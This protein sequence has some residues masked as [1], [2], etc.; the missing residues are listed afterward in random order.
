M[1]ALLYRDAAAWRPR[2]MA[3]PYMVALHYGAA[4]L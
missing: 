2:I 3:A 1:A 4:A